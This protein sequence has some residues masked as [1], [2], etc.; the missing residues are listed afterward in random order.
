MP[1]C[2]KT[3]PPPATGAVIRV[4]APFPLPPFRRGAKVLS[5]RP[6]SASPKR[7]QRK[8][9]HYPDCCGL[10]LV[11]RP[12]PPEGGQQAGGVELLRRGIAG[13]RNSPAVACSE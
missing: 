8:R 9:R 5:P 6:Y 3:G 1:H 4:V 7:R 13:A 10:L 12:R 11:P 2:G